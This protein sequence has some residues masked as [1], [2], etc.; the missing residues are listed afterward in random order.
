MKLKECAKDSANLIDQRQQELENVMDGFRL[1]C[2]GFAGCFGEGRTWWG[3][4]C[5]LTGVYNKSHEAGQDWNKLVDEV[6]C[7]FTLE[8]MIEYAGG[9]ASVLIVDPSTR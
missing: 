3:C 2:L 8:T 4:C 7:L 1:S 9:P 6:L 5:L